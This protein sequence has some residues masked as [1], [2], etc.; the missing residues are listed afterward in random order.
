M[1]DRLAPAS[2]AEN[3]DEI[4]LEMST[5]GSLVLSGIKDDVADGSTG[6]RDAVELIYRAMREARPLT[7]SALASSARFRQLLPVSA[8]LKMSRTQPD[9]AR[10]ASHRAD[11]SVKRRKIYP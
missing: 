3:S 1:A 10:A 8:F 9:L 6:L 4:T 5:A 11:A 2:D 7:R